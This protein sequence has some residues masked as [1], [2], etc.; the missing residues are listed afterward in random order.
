MRRRLDGSA[1]RRIKAMLLRK[2]VSAS[3]TAKGK[4]FHRTTSKPRNGTGSLPTK[5]SQWP[6]TISRSCITKAAACLRTFAL[7]RRG[8]AWL[9][10]RAI[11]MQQKIVI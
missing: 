1:S 5:A 3:F 6:R 2:L 10:R 9:R 8:S 11:R 4:A 7:R